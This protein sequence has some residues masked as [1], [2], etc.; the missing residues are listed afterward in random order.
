VRR[1][2]TY[3]DVCGRMLTYADICRKRASETQRVRRARL[4]K[5]L[6]ESRCSVYLPYWYTSTNTDAASAVARMQVLS[7]LALLVYQYKN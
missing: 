5:L 3:A 4:R 6:R 2:L 1:M 7:L